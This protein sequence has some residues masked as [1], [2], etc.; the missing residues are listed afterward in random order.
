M[1]IRAQ[2]PSFVMA[3]RGPQLA[4]LPNTTERARETSPISGTGLFGE[5]YENNRLDRKL[6]IKDF[7]IL[8]ANVPE[9]GR[10]LEIIASHVTSGDHTNA[11][12]FQ[13][14]WGPRATSLH[15]RIAEERIKALAM[16]G[17]ARSWTMG[18][19]K[20]GDLFRHLVF[21]QNGVIVRLNRLEP[22]LMTI[23]HDAYGNPYGYRFAGFKREN[24]DLES[25]EV[26]HWAHSPDDDSQPYGR[27]LFDSGRQIGHRVLT[28]RDALTYETLVHSTARN[29]IIL[30]RPSEMP[31]PK[32]FDWLDRIKEQFKREKIVDSNGILSR[33]A[34]TLLNSQNVF[35]DVPY[36]V[37]TGR[38]LGEPKI[39]PLQ[40]TPIAANAEIIRAMAMILFIVTGVPPEYFSM[41]Q[42]DGLGSNRMTLVDLQFAMQLNAEQLQLAWFI[43]QIL[44]RQF[45]ALG[46]PLGEG[47]LRI[48]M[49]DL[50]ALD[51][52]VRG[53]IMW[54]RIQAAEKAKAIG[55]G[56]KYIWTEILCDGSVTDA[57]EMAERYGIPEDT[58]RAASPVA[59][60]AQV[61]QVLT[62][63]GQLLPMVRH[64]MKVTR[65]A[66][67]T[68][69]EP[70]REAA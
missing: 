54:L 7:D 62:E 29:A 55:L 42:S 18:A 25:W 60:A 32:I 41:G 23:K 39:L 27:S 10:S 14:E 28:L 68:S 51:E 65:G 6:A 53:E 34:I 15:K 33:K 8:A 3:D 11:K 12:G 21:D 43:L 67:A 56:W 30:P 69:G 1:G 45:I 20:A 47:D 19:N 59:T 2:Q 36:D 38:M 66:D 16:R 58:D 4:P 70:Q 5:S 44:E 63:M 26:V 48:A 31:E 17:H 40:N 46:I 22:G 13:L 61:E 37:D 64:A 50:R 35:L 24:A 57:Q 49:P 52:K 9:F